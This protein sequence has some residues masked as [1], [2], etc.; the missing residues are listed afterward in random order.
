M[1]Y[2]Y[3]YVCSLSGAGPH[4]KSMSG[5]VISATW[6]VFAVLL[7]ACYFANFNS[8]LN[9]DTKHIT[10]NSFEDLANQDVIEYGTVN[11]GS[12]M[13]FFKASIL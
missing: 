9:S 6:W 4:P 5:R 1:F 3:L 8:M 13:S 10:I 7:L 11:G 12:T 2:L